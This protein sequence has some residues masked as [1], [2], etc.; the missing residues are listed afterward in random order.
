MAQT[1]YNSA[2]FIGFDAVREV[3]TQI[4]PEI[5]LGAYV[6]H[7]QFFKKLYVNVI[8]GDEFRNVKYIML[9]KGHT[10]RQ[11][12]MGD[13]I[14]NTAGRLVE[15]EMVTYLA[16]NR[17]RVNKD[18]F[19]CLPT[20]IGDQISYPEA[21]ATIK[22][23]VEEFTNDVFDNIVH[24]DIENDKLP[25]TSGLRH[26]GLF[27]G[28][29][30]D[31]ARD[32]AKGD[33]TPITLTN[34]FDEPTGPTDV[35]AW[36]AW[37]EL[38]AALDPALRNAPKT[39]YIMTPQ[40]AEAIATAYANWK[41]NH[42]GFEFGRNELG[43]YTIPGYPTDEICFDDNLGVG[44]KV[45]VTVP[46]NLEYG[47]D[48]RKGN[49]SFSVEPETSRDNDDFILQPKAAHGT[50]VFRV[51][52]KHFAITDGSLKPSALAADYYYSNLSLFPSDVTL[53]KIQVNGADLTDPT[54]DYEVGTNVTIKAVALDGATFEKWSNG[55]T[56]AEITLTVGAQPLALVAIFKKS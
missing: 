46:G 39:L 32:I 50:R 29:M 18:Q 31:I 40:N 8:S 52:K 2:P 23:A 37:K 12:H 4:M 36:L 9:T 10:S 53:G 13:T 45:I 24:G 7:E 43:N 27:D 35:R 33:V 17:F 28:W 51:D 14:E 15:R 44:D 26:L 21:A 30:T 48:T 47:V 11:W 41:G 25:E 56:D 55:S 49:Y 16:W 6:D 42:P 54:K 1:N 3:G 19:R 5:A 22:A 34:S 38:R 20:V